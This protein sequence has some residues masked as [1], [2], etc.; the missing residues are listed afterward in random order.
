[1]P[2][3]LENF[4]RGERSRAASWRLTAGVDVEIET[5]GGSVVAARV[6]RECPLR[7][8]CSRVSRSCAAEIT[9]YFPA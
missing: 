2:F 6:F 5:A 3:T 4:A 1:M 7:V 9:P 8:A